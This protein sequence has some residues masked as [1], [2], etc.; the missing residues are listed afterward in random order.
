MCTDQQHQEH[1]DALARIEKTFRNLLE[2]RPP[3]DVPMV[4]ISATTAYILDY[5]NRKYVY[6]SSANSL[7]L[8]L[9]DLGTVSVSANALPILLPYP[10][11]LRIFAQ[12][13]SSNVMIYIR[14]TDDL[15]W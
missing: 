2:T 11:G 9:E 1:L 15:I 4:A 14:C 10:P 13:Q 6:V 7:T 8:T 3:V 5:H 12:G